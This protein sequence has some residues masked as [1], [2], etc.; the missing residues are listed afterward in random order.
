MLHRLLAAALL[1]SL[2]Q[3][4]LGACS[5][6]YITYTDVDDWVEGL[7]KGS[8]AKH[9]LAGTNETPIVVSGIRVEVMDK[10]EAETEHV[11]FR[12]NDVDGGAA[13]GAFLFVHGGGSFKGRD[14]TF[15]NGKATNGGHVFID[16]EGDVTCDRCTFSNGEAINGGAVMNNADGTFTCN[17]CTFTKNTGQNGGA[18]FNRVGGTVTL[19]EPIFSGNRRNDCHGVMAH[20]SSAINAAFAEAPTALPL[21]IAATTVAFST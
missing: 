20:C 1:T 4:A 15:T 8:D 21:M 5:E 10:K 2:L 14:T 7:E 12:D 9:C 19:T 18:I 16:P 6:G 3:V 17:D 13:N 11:I